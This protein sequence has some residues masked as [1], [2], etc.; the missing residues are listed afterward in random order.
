MVDT[1]DDYPSPALST[2]LMRRILG[3]VT[4]PPRAYALRTMLML[5]DT[6]EPPP[7]EPEPRPRRTWPVIVIRLSWRLVAGLGFVLLSG[8]FPPVE[9]YA[10]LL[11]GCVLIGR[12]FAA[13]LQST[14]GLKDYHQ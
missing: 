3:L 12:G 11:A 1:L 8:V 5:I 2:R 13:I 6:R 9:A 10:V 7:R 4:G 14:P